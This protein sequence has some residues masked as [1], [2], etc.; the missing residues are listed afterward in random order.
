MSLK[1]FLKWQGLIILLLAQ[2]GTMADNAGVSVSATSLALALN[3]QMS[4]IAIANAMYPLIA[5]SLMIALGTLGLFL[6]WVRTFQI[7]VALLVVAEFVAA[8]T[9]DI[10][11]FNFVARS[12]AGTGASF[13]IPSVLGLVAVLYSGKD[14]VV[15]FSAIGAVVGVANIV[16]PLIFGYIID[17]FSYRVAFAILSLFFILLFA[18]SFLLPADRDRESLKNYDGIGALLASFGL[19]MFSGGLMQLS[20]W[21]LIKPINAPFTVFGLSPCLPLIIAGLAVLVGFWRFEVRR[22]EKGLNCLVPVSFFTTAQIRGG[23]YM[24]AFMFFVLGSFTILCIPYLQ[25]VA[26]YSAFETSFV[27]LLFAVGM[28]LSSLGT[29][30]LLPQ[31]SASL[32]CRSGMAISALACLVGGL[33]LTLDGI[34]PVF[35]LAIFMIGLGTGLIASQASIIVTEAVDQKL[36]SQSGAVQAASRNIGQAIGV[37]LVA[38]MLM[39]ALTGDFKNN[40]KLQKD[41]SPE[42]VNQISEIAAIPLMSNA[43]FNNAMTK[44]KVPA[45]DRETFSAI[46]R[47]ARFEASRNSWLALAFLFVMTIPLL[48]RSIPRHS[49]M[50]EKREG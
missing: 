29:P 17:A 3:A 19:L 25:M 42:I 1:S 10:T 46:N 37:A 34:S 39:F 45:A 11:V 27:L 30:A 32:I 20:T 22:A 7:G 8:T 2:F 48:T 18:A 36:A 31:L 26:D 41:V 47:Q 50:Q 12:L 33:G 9:H 5:G 43:D 49:L 28:V 4:Q 13:L 16:A 6:G 21:G 23:I 44:F 38:W 14:R 24:C 35:F 15:A 40:A